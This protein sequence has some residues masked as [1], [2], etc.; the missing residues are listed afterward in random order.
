MVNL[1]FWKSWPFTHRLL[2]FIGVIATLTAMMYLSYGYIKGP[3][4]VTQWEIRY[5]QHTT[6]TEVASFETGGFQFV[7][8]ADLYLTYAYFQG[9]PIQPKPIVGLIF[10]AGLITSVLFLLTLITTLPRFWFFAGMALFIIFMV[11]LRLEVVYLFQ[12]YGR[13]IPLA[14]LALPVAL[15]FYFSVV[16][17][18]TSLLTRF[19]SFALLTTGLAV[20]I[21]TFSGVAHPGFHLAVTGYWPALIITLLFVLMIAHEIPA[22]FVYLAAQAGSGTKNALHFTLLSLLYLAFVF[23]LYFDNAGI[24]SL[25]I[26]GFFIYFLLIISAIL[27][28]SGFRQREHLYENIFPFAPTGALFYVSLAAIALF[29]IG[30]A[31]S[32]YNDASLKVIRDIILFSHLGYGIIFFTYVVSNF[33]AMMA[34]NLPAHKVLY[35]PNRMPYFTFRLAGF[36][37]TLAFVFYMNWKEYVYHAMGGYYN[38]LGDLHQ[39]LDKPALAEA[40]YQQVK[41]YA[42]QNNRANY[43]LAVNETRRYSREQA[44]DLYELA[45]ARHPSVY[46][47]INHG[48][49]FARTGSWFEAI[50]LY[51]KGLEKFNDPH[52][53]L[54]LGYAYAHVHK[55][56]SALYFFELARRNHS[57]KAL[58]ESNF[59]ALTGQ[60]YMP[61]KVDSVSATFSP[62]A[63]LKSN[64]LALAAQRKQSTRITPD[65]VNSKTPLDVATATLLHNYLIARLGRHDTVFLNKVLQVASDS[66]NEDFSEALKA[67]LA[68][69]YYYQLQPARALQL[70]SEVSFTS[71]SYESR[72]QYLMGLWTLEQH[73][74]EQSVY[75]FIRA[76]ETGYK[77][78][79][80]YLAIARAE[81]GFISE[82]L[83]TAVQLTGQSDSLTASIGRKLKKILTA[84]PQQLDT[85]EERFLFCHYRLKSDDV[86]LFDVIVNQISDNN[87]RALSILEMST[88]QLRAGNTEQAATLTERLSE[89]TLTDRTV[90]QK[91][92]QHELLLHAVTGNVNAV[93]AKLTPELTFIGF[94]NQNRIL[95]EALLAEQQGDSVRAGNLFSMLGRNNPFFEEGVLEAASYFYRHTEDKMVTYQMLADAIHLNRY[96]Y[97][98]LN[99]YA[100]IAGELGFD[101]YARGAKEQAEEIRKRM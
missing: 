48:N 61:L 4:A 84:S 93:K 55:T 77:D 95:Y 32:A 59:L 16:R 28:F 17:P 26:P 9:L 92:V 82:A 63:E 12:V 1:Q 7:V 74:P 69:A 35:K 51:R 100:R 57:V 3:S 98:L 81:A 97:R 54:N 65:E 15:A 71:Q 76:A 68:Y 19:L 70:L 94:Q 88:R 44:A 43:Q 23:M 96:S 33:M 89:I 37:A 91:V 101:V 78:A 36:I 39:L 27:G 53:A 99:A 30:Y 87:Y 18:Q 47:L 85:D 67:A 62:S 20:I 60:E 58:A 72:Y 50:R 86:K 25:N 45:N 41:S 14:I 22:S 13:T 8:P 2:L 90:A 10:I 73:A 11:S 6:E 66:T 49:L 29:F 83:Q 24:I 52:L 64:A 56:D 46:S 5:A 75:H 79:V 40:F 34:R 42:F 80:S 38:N 31:L 21:T